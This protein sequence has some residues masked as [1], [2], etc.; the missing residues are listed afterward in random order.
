MHYNDQKKIHQNANGGYIKVIRPQVLFSSLIALNYSIKG[1]YNFLI[2]RLKKNSI[3]STKTLISFKN[4][5][6]SEVNEI[7]NFSLLLGHLAS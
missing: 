4:L 3:Y 5:H 2:R 6:Y 1:L 7:F